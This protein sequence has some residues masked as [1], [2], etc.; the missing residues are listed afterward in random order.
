MNKLMLKIIKWYQNNISVNTEPSCRHT[1][2]CSNYAKECYTRF[3]FFKA[4]FL[5]SK[6]LLTCN[7][8]FKPRYDPVPEKRS[9][10]KKRK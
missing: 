4:T 5:S 3:N 8:L 10:K 2:T 1:P 7:P 9:K 6:R